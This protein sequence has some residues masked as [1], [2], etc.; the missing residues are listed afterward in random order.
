MAAPEEPK[1]EL[2][3]LTHGR[4]EEMRL[5][6]RR[7]LERGVEPQIV[8]VPE[9]QASRGLYLLAVFRR[10]HETAVQVLDEVWQETL[11]E[12]PAAEVDSEVAGCPAC[13]IA[14]EGLPEYCPECGIRL[15]HA[16]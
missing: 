13:G 1:P 5:L 2:V 9:L 16:E 12:V 15:G 7:L 11:P 14:L 4:L 8:T 6:R 3:P 10:D